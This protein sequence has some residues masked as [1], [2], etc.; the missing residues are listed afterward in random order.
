MLEI[1]FSQSDDELRSILETYR[2]IAMVDESNNHC[3][4]IYQVTQYLKEL[5]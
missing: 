3:Y 1:D 5:R 2:V 4:N